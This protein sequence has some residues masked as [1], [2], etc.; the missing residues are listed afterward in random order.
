M[1]KCSMGERNERRERNRVCMMS[2]KSRKGLIV[3]SKPRKDNTWLHKDKMEYK[4]ISVPSVKISV[5]ML[6][7]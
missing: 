3:V 6:N 2:K 7:N 5:T 4:K 1:M